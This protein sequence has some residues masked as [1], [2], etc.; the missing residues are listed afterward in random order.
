MACSGTGNC[1][2]EDCQS[3]CDLNCQVLG[4]CVCPTGCV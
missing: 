3:G 4:T 1:S 2:L